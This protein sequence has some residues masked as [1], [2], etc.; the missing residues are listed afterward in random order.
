MVPT[1]FIVYHHLTIRVTPV[2]ELAP[3]LLASS[4][5]SLASSAQRSYQMT[6]NCLPHGDL[7]RVSSEAY[8]SIRFDQHK[9]VPMK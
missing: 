9:Y 3:R 6:G 4:P 2:K 1:L 5:G 7:I 8:T